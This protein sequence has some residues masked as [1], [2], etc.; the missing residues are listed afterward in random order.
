MIFNQPNPYGHPN[1]RTNTFCVEASFLSDYQTIC[2]LRGKLWLISNF[3]NFVA[4]I[5][6]NC[7]ELSFTSLIKT[8]H[9]YATLNLKTTILFIS[10]SLAA[11]KWFTHLQ[12]QVW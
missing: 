12:C 8:C 10:S 6:A 9:S 11:L 7:N 4:K 1:F 3:K 5:L 2:N